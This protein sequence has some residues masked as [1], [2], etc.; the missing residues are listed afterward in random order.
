[1]SQ[2]VLH[3]LVESMPGGVHTVIKARGGQT[4]TKINLWSIFRLWCDNMNHQVFTKTC[5][6]HASWMHFH[7]AKGRYTITKKKHVVLL[8][9]HAQMI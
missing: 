1:M 3:Q 8:R 7:K 4:I 6:V 9:N 2:Q 5:G